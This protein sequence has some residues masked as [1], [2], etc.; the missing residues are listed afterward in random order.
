MQHV[1]VEK[2]I[3]YSSQSPP[4]PPI[5]SL[6]LRWHPVLSRFYPRVKRLHEK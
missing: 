6:V 3:D 4:P 1:H 5:K 2:C